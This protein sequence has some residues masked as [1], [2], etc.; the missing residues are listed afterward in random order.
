MYLSKPVECTAP[1]VN[2]KVISI[3]WVIMMFQCRFILGNK[4]TI[5]VSDIDHGG[6]YACVWSGDLWKISVPYSQF[7]CEPKTVLK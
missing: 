3:F 7:Y 6:G 5:L 1:R 4:C 2:P